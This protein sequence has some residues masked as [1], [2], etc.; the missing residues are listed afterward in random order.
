MSWQRGSKPEDWSVDDRTGKIFYT[1]PVEDHVGFA[2]PLD[3]RGRALPNIRL[4]HAAGKTYELVDHPWRSRNLCAEF[5]LPVC[6]PDGSPYK[7]EVLRIEREVTDREVDWDSDMAAE[8][9]LSSDGCAVSLRVPMRAFT[10]KDHVRV[11][12]DP[13][14]ID[15]AAI[16]PPPPPAAP[17]PVEDTAATNALSE[18]AAAVDSAAR[19]L[20]A[21]TLAS[22]V[23]RAKFYDKDGTLMRSVTVTTERR[24]SEVLH[25]FLTAAGTLELP[26]THS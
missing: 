25:H 26:V 9:T 20:A 1:G 8:R 6:W 23:K 16:S 3:A 12:L 18:A 5:V 14:V 13:V 11:F 24:G 4:S 19:A 17:A 22:P 2:L 15:V 21:S 7:T 10:E